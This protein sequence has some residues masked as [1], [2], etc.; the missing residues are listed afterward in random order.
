LYILKL[1]SYN[2]IYLNSDR[3]WIWQ[4]LPSNKS[5][6]LLLLMVTLHK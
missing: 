6:L 5:L 3:Y 1:K 2:Y 4:L